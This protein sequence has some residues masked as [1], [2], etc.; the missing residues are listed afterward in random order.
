M[1]VECRPV[2]RGAGR[3]RAAQGH[4]PTRLR[5]MRAADAWMRQH[6]RLR[7]TAAVH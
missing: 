5:A 6:L 3:G 1:E 4:A 7:R 2:G